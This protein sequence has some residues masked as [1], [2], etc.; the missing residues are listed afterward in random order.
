MSGQDQTQTV[1][2]KADETPV[3]DQVDVKPAVED[4]ENQKRLSGI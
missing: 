3:P 4:S 2:Q 1:T